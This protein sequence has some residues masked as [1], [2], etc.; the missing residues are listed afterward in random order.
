MMNFLRRIF[1]WLK[2]ALSVFGKK[3]PKDKS[4]VPDD[5]YPMW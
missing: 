3:K 1:A 4:A 2:T 5:R